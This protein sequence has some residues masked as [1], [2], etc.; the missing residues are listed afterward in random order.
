MNTAVESSPQRL[1]GRER[2]RTQR[3]AAVQVPDY[4]VVELLESS[5]VTAGPQAIP[6]RF[7]LE[8]LTEFFEAWADNH[9][10]PLPLDH[11]FWLERASR[12]A[13]DDAMTA[14]K[15]VGLLIFREARDKEPAG[16]LPSRHAISLL[17]RDPRNVLAL[18]GNAAIL[19]PSAT[20]DSLHVDARLS[21]LRTIEFLSPH[22]DVTA[23][24]LSR[25]LSWSPQGVSH[26]MKR[27][28]GN[29][30]IE[31]NARA[32]GVLLT[33]DGAQVL[34]DLSRFRGPISSPTRFSRKNLP[35]DLRTEIPAII[36]RL[37]ILTDYSLGFSL[38]EIGEALGLPYRATIRSKALSELIAEGTILQE[39][40]HYDMH[41]HELKRLSSPTVL[42]RLALTASQVGE[43]STDLTKLAQE[44][45]SG[46]TSRQRTDRIKR[47][48][49]R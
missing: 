13:I 5:V 31:M 10:K 35:E 24:A 18:T 48:L 42:Y 29:D 1:S 3:P 8:V 2:S 39:K 43:P 21:L 36:K 23:Q 9:C 34:A 4:A 16:L 45:R 27:L 26:W 12:N 19:Q 41:H 32:T 6:S 47:N 30:L 33:K 46:M 38:R 22:G 40:R 20:F 7:A 44:I 11:T 49:S 28:A 37:S 15:R 25:A 14:L 17:W